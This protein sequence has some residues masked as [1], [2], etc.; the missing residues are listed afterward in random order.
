MYII[1]FV[2]LVLANLFLFQPGLWFYQDQSFWSKNLYEAYLYL[3]TQFYTFNTLSYY[4]GYDQGILSANN[5]TTYSIIYLLVGL[6]GSTG[7]Q[8]AFSIIGYLLAFISFFAFSS[9]FFKDRKIQLILALL[10]TFNP[11]LYSLRGQSLV[12]AVAPLFIYS[13]YKY[14]LSYTYINKY[15]LLNIFTTSIWIANVRF[16]QLDFFIILPYLVYLIVVSKQ[17]IKRKIILYTCINLALFSPVIY[18]LISPLLQKEPSIFNYGTIF[19]SV[20]VNGSFSQMFN[21]FQSSNIFIYNSNLFPIIGISIFI[22]TILLLLHAIGTKNSAL[23]RLNLALLLFGMTLTQLGY[24]LNKDLYTSILKILPFLTNGP[25]YGLYIMNIPFLLLLGAIAIKNVKA[26]YFLAALFITVGIIPMLNINNFIFQKYQLEKMPYSYNQY[27]VEPYYGLPEATHYIPYPC[28]RA[29]YMQDS[30]TPTQCFNRGIKYSSITYDNPR[31]VSGKELYLVKEL[32]LNPN[33][34]NLRVTH[35]LKN[36][37]VAKDIVSTI[38]AGPLYSAKDIEKVRLLDKAFSSNKKLSVENKNNF[39]HYYYTDKDSYDFFLY[40]PKTVVANSTID[41]IFDNSLNV[42]D[43]PVLLSEADSKKIADV[44][45]NAKITYKRST[46]D[47]TKYYVEIDV[48]DINKSLIIH[49]AQAYKSN[50]E[51]A[52]ISKEEYDSVICSSPIQ[53]YSVTKNASCQYQST[54]IDFKALNLLLKSYSDSQNHMQGNH[55]GN[56]WRINVDEVPSSSKEGSKIY[57][58]LVY[59]SQGYYMIG[60]LAS[61][62]V[63][64]FLIG[65][66]FIRSL[67]NIFTK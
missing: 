16:L 23:I 11:L 37:I 31:V 60:L 38:D 2:L 52:W 29:Q 42:E 39:N 30:N 66:T 6:F 63:L 19:S 27:F 59:K 13:F 62:I 57:A 8:V 17:F 3:N 9:L 48:Q 58:V 41:T 20:E 46:T 45:Q 44:D 67:R 43:V 12:Y 40:S 1:F 56:T 24:I 10:F 61:A 65:Y 53:T 18:A 26:F 15:L 36:I 35:N 55:I 64:L 51:I 7:S 32:Y 25:H 28:W 21:F 22:V 47:A 49:L 14:Y 33:V 5:I 34:D 50:W 4:I 54:L